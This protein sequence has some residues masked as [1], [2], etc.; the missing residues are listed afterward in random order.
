MFYVYILESLTNERHYVGH[1]E[2][3]KTRLQ[4]HNTGKVKS[5]KA[6]MPWRLV[7]S[8]SFISKQDA[9]KR[10]RQIKSYKGGEAFK[11]LLK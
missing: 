8:E 3:M 9:Y 4:R 7:Y 11:K 5:T 1:T 6:F 2:D 10:E